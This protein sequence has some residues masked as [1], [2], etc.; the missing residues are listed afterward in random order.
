VESHPAELALA[1]EGCPD[2]R[3]LALEDYPVELG[4]AMKGHPAEPGF[5][6]EGRPPEPGPAVED[7]PDQP[8]FAVG[9]RS[10]EP[11]AAMEVRLLEPGCHECRVAV[12]VAWCGS[13][14]PLKERLGDRHAT[15]VDLAAF[16][17]LLERRVSLLIASVGQALRSCSEADADAA[18]VAA[19]R[20]VDARLVRHTPPASSRHLA[21]TVSAFM[22][23]SSKFA[24]C[25][26]M[27]G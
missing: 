1:V 20:P 22:R 6:V 2:E 13:E 11:G 15:C 24:I 18:V 10:A 21:Y 12:R 19:C 3:G 27:P 5:V 16:G 8:G 14:D 7:R 26:G 25:C 4:F 9:D 17:E 23:C